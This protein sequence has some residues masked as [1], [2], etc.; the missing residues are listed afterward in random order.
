M[1]GSKDIDRTRLG[2]Q[3]DIPTDIQTVAKLFLTVAYLKNSNGQYTEENVS[4]CSKIVG[5]VG[6]AI[7][8]IL[9]ADIIKDHTFSI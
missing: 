7:E 6:Q 4:E 8:K 1:K 9:E 2:L 5:S 3:T